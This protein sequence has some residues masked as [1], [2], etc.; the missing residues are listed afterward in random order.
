MGSPISGFIA[1]AVLQRLESLVF[2][3]H[4][5]T[6][7]ARYVDDTFVVID[8][9]QLLTFKE[10]LNAVFPD[11]QF[12]M[13]EEENNQLAFLDVLV[14]RKDC[15]GLKTKVFRKATNTMQIL[16]FNCN[17]PISHKGS[18]VRTLYRR[19]E[20]HC[21]EPDDKIAELQYLR[22]V[23]KANGYPGNFVDRCIRKRDERPSRTDT[24][25]WRALPCCSHVGRQS[26]SGPQTISVSPD[27]ESDA[28]VIQE[29]GH[30][31]G[32]WYEHI[33]PDR[34]DYVEIIKENIQPG[35]LR[36]FEKL[37][38][39]EV[40][41]LGEEYD[42]SSIMHFR[43][44]AFAKP[45]TNETMRPKQ[46]CPRPVIGEATQPSAGDFRQVNKL[47][48]CPCRYC[49]SNLPPMLV[50][51]SSRMLIEY[52]WSAGQSSTGFVADYRIVC[53]ESL[54]ADKGFFISPGYPSNYL[55]NKQCIWKIAVSAGF[56]VV[57]SFVTFGLEEQ[58]D[59]SYNHLE[60]FDGP[61]ESSPILRKLCGLDKPATIISTS[62][63]V[64]VRFTTDSVLGSQRF[65]ASFEK[66]DCG[67]VVYGTRGTLSTPFHPEN[68]HPNQDCAWNITAPSNHIILFTFTKFDLQ[69]GSGK[70]CLS[71]FVRVYSVSAQN[72]TRINTFCGQKRPQ[73]LISHSS[74]LR[75]LFHSDGHLERT[76]FRAAFYTYVNNC[77][78]SNG[79]CQH[80][81]E[82]GI[83]KHKCKCRSGYKLQNV[84]ECIKNVEAELQQLRDISY[85]KEYQKDPKYRGA[86]FKPHHGCLAESLELCQP[87]V[88]TTIKVVDA[89]FRSCRFEREL[90]YTTPGD[91]DLVDR[92]ISFEGLV[93]VSE[94]EWAN[95]R[96][97]Q[98][99]MAY[100]MDVDLTKVVFAH[101]NGLAVNVKPINNLN[102][103]IVYS[104]K[105][106]CTQENANSFWTVIIV[107]SALSNY[108]RRLQLR[109]VIRRQVAKLGVKVGVLFSLGLPEN[110]QIAP[111]LLKEV[112]QF[113]DILLAS[114]TD[115]YHN[116]TLKTISNL[117]FVHHNCLHTS[118]SFVFLDDDH[119][120][121]LQQL[122]QF[123]SNLSLVEVRRSV[124]GLINY[125]K[126][127]IRDADHKWF[128]SMSDYPF[129]H[130]PDYPSG[131]C[132]IIGAGIIHKLSIAAAFTRLMPNE[133][134][135]VG[136]MLMKLGVNVQT[137]PNIRIHR[138]HFPRDFSPL[139]A[140]LQFFAKELDIA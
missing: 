32:L 38:R 128:T 29:L 41:S 22:R 50:S 18:R 131:P 66:A 9:D 13:E 98:A 64:T 54:K 78:V 77:T 57:L 80:I 140:G 5:P 25:S 6:F 106:V 20:T 93:Y 91:N 69:D 117:R 79:G 134:V 110:G 2:Q 7:W 61:S 15:G 59:C 51:E 21:S 112:A 76:G 30:I 86:L 88:S 108:A 42:Y 40:D 94:D 123:F 105:S 83:P 37:T 73:S 65:A 74:E 133:D 3:H 109:E 48:K 63:R 26:N 49:G 100:P 45:G 34:D 114:Y 23:F 28:G 24:K 16:N 101:S 119:G 81:C 118:P 122:R 14:C 87:D 67:G 115:T 10:R 58:S 137:L 70:T 136:M 95:V 19:V 31:L 130:Y 121:N 139:A 75:V 11:I 113:D 36:H 33:R 138:S 1:E 89:H 47:Y 120:I 124:F 56:A 44:D 68:Y 39:A 111:K 35:M 129:P 132:Y 60:I 84:S 103:S 46:C 107:K 82:S 102:I 4:K 135:Y 62:N 12:T 17:H 104:S 52:K 90:F 99:Y 55:P 71:D 85:E 53:G 125:N 126:P 116:L 43:R 97:P 27:C 92:C 72:T 127:V 8:R 96:I